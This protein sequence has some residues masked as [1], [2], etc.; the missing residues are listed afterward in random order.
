MPK[1]LFTLCLLLVPFFSGCDKNDDFRIPVATV[2]IRIYPAQWSKYGV[3]VFPDYQKFIF[4]NVPNK[5]FY[6]MG[7]YLTGYGG[8]L[9]ICGYTNQLYAYDLACPVER[10]PAIRLDI[11]DDHACCP[12][13]KSTYDVY[14]GTGAPTSGTAHEHKYMLRKYQ[15]INQNGTYNIIN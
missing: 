14:G 7:S 13:C 12:Q 4:N 10:D 8:I 3:H 5:E 1:Y 9:L 15:V 2:N 11:E 6:T